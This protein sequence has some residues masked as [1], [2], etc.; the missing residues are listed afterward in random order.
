MI[1]VQFLIPL[2][3]WSKNNLCFKLSSEAKHAFAQS[4]RNAP[5][6]QYI[7]IASNPCGFEEG[8]VGFI[9]DTKNYDGESLDCVGKLWVDIEPE[10]Q[11]LERDNNGSIT[12]FILNSISIVPHRGKTIDD[13]A[14]P[15]Q[16]L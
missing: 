5:I 2:D 11:I 16:P 12:N 6:V 7:S 9:S 8:V 13:A 10:A 3:Y 1:E 4:V 15:S 14:S